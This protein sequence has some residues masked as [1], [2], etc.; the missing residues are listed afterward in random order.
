[1]AGWHTAIDIYCERVDPSFW[2]EPL[3]AVSNGAFVVA[4]VFVGWRIL[5]HRP[6]DRP[7]LFF[8]VLI[9]V[10][11]IGSFL[12]HTFAT[13]WSAVADVVPIMLFIH[14][15][16]F[17]AMRRFFGLGILA[18]LLIAVVFFV[19][20][21]AFAASL[22][23]GFL[24]G[25]GSYLPALA[26]LIVIGLVLRVRANHAERW[27]AS[28]KTRIYE[29]AVD[30]EEARASRVIRPRAAALFLLL[31]GLVFAVSVTFR[32]V[33]MAVCDALP[34][35]VHYMWHVLNAVVLGLA[36]EATRRGLPG[37]PSRKTVAAA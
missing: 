21:G 37:S 26:A 17:L 23:D 9:G 12:F 4:A 10:I 15:F 18:S 28:P 36:V 25:S 20:S 11:G 19:L 5:S 16:L 30:E 3:N 14:G 1:M 13:R 2:A 22:P 24:N 34:I 35:G 33:D 8:A 31:A 7:A 27:L 32:S 29:T 6:L